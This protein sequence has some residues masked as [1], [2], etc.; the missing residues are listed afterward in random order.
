MIPEHLRVID[1][2][3]LYDVQDILDDARA[4][5]QLLKCNRPGYVELGPQLIYLSKADDKLELALNEVRS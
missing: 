1:E 2:C 5:L 4:R 3:E